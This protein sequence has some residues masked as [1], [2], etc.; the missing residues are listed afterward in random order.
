[1]TPMTA[2]LL[3]TSGAPRHQGKKE[4]VCHGG[5]GVLSDGMGSWTGQSLLHASTTT[6]AAIGHRGCVACARFRFRPHLRYRWCLR[7]RRI[8][9]DDENQFRRRSVRF[10]IEE[11]VKNLDISGGLLVLRLEG[12]ASLR[13]RKGRGITSHPFEATPPLDESPCT[14]DNTSRVEVH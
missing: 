10:V 14:H 6:P 13:F 2:S 1:M 5:N 12:G 7:Q 9:P 4:D 8:Y 3:E 11:G